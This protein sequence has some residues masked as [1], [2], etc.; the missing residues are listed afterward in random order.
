[1]PRFCGWKTVPTMPIMQCSTILW[2]TTRTLELTSFWRFLP[3]ISSFMTSYFLTS[4]WPLMTD[5]AQL[6][7]KQGLTQLCSLTLHHRKPT[8]KIS[9]AL[10][11]QL[12]FSCKTLESRTMRL[13][14]LKSNTE[15]L[16][17]N[18]SSGYRLHMKAIGIVQRNSPHCHTQSNSGSWVVINNENILDGCL[19]W[20]NIFSV[21][22]TD[23]QLL[24][25][26]L[27]QY[28]D[29]DFYPSMK[30]QKNFEKKVFN[31]THKADS[32]NLSLSLSCSLSLARLLTP[33]IVLHSHTHLRC[34]LFLILPSSSSRPERDTSFECFSH[35]CRAAEESGH[36]S[37][38]IERLENGEA[39]NVWHVHAEE[40]A[41]VQ[42]GSHLTPESLPWFSGPLYSLF[43]SKLLLH[44]SSSV[45]LSSLM[46]CYM[47]PP[48]LH[49]ALPLSCHSLRSLGFS[50]PSS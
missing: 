35:Y 32:K 28:Y 37:V 26:C 5:F 14:A 21:L 31:K 8:C 9:R 43:C 15:T 50:H 6:P 2:L 18:I 44:S 40:H 7:P 46:L 33:A 10:C 41:I 24:L 39:F 38:T 42:D 34:Q 45:F 4:N 27:L 23:P 30:D 25:F 29:H 47:P 36:A 49:L 3:F 48:S 12:W 22:H 16:H 13:T 11:G 19:K 17:P 1:M 20:S